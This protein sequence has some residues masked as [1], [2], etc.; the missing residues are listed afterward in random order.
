[1]RDRRLSEA[2]G[3]WRVRLLAN[4]VDPVDYE[5]I[6]GGVEEWAGWLSAW[7]AGAEVH[8][9][10]G[11]EALADGRPLSAGAHLRRAAIYFHFAKF[12]WVHD[13]EAMRG[14]HERALS[15]LAASLD[16]LRPPGRRVELPLGG[17]RMVGVLRVPAA[18]EPPPVV[19]MLPGLDSTKEELYVT[20]ELFLERGLATFAVDGPGQGEA[21]YDLAIRGDW[22]EP[23]AA[24]CDHLAQTPEVDDRRAGIWGVSLGGYYAARAAAAEGRLRACISLS[25]PFSFGRNWESL[26]LLTRDAFRVRSFSESEAE[27]RAKASELSLEGRAGAIR[28]PLLVVA[29]GRDA[30][31]PPEDAERLAAE[32]AGPVDLLLLEEGDHNCMNMTYRHRPFAADW[33]AAKLGDLPAPTAA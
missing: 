30:I 10:L 24:I 11:R 3:H 15:C 16:H 8:E 1:M 22:E 29:G 12:F 19:V 20:E 21:E 4:G 14:A 28:V 17:S 18:E 23:A 26:P 6:T 5:R 13:R 33:M 25:G 32:A 31:V 9:M 7:C 27:A 2:I